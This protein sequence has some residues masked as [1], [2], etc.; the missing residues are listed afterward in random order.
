MS[1]LT[2]RHITLI[3]P[4]KLHYSYPRQ[5]SPLSR[6]KFLLSSS[7]HWLKCRLSQCRSRFSAGQIGQIL[8]SPQ[9]GSVMASV[10]PVRVKS[11]HSYRPFQVTHLHLYCWGTARFF[12][13]SSFLS[14]YISPIVHIDS[15]FGLT[16]QQYADDTQLYIAIY[17]SS[18]SLYSYTEI[19]RKRSHSI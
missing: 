5:Y 7:F 8:Q 11:V 15:S 1:I 9:P 13:V 4:Y 10:I 3:T 14:L 6:P 12:S 18:L 19:R 2:S 16:Q 17:S